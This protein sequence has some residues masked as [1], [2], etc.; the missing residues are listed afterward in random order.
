MELD[1]SSRRWYVTFHPTGVIKSI[2]HLIKIACDR[3]PHVAIAA[4]KTRRRTVILNFDYNAV[5]AEVHDA[6]DA[7]SK[8]VLIDTDDGQCRKIK[9]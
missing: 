7:W 6:F 1:I 9:R 2:R 4:C 5:F 3:L 8:E